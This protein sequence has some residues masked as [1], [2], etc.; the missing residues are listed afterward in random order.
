MED[1][2]YIVVGAGFAGLTA[3]LRLT[4]AG[5]SVLVIEARD[6][7]GGRTFTETRADGSYI[8]HG[9]TW[10]GPGQDRIHA[11][12]AELG[13][14]SYKQYVDG[15]AMMLVD[16]KAHRYGGTIPWSMRPW[17]SGNLATAFLELRR[18]CASIPV[19]APWDAARAVRWDATTLAQWL[20]WHVP[21]RQ[22]RR[23]LEMALAG[24]YTSAASEL[25]LLFVVFQLASAGGPDFVLGVEGAAED[26]RPVGGMGAIYR[27]MADRLADVLSLGAPARS[28]SQDSAGVTVRCDSREVR[29]SRVIVAVPVAIAGQ[30]VYEPALPVDRSLLHQRM[31]SGAVLKCHALYDEPF[32]RADGLTG[33]SAAPGTAAAVTIDAGMHE[34]GPGVLAI[35]TEGPTARTLSRMA[36]ADR[37]AAIIDALAHRFGPKASVPIEFTQQDWTAEQYSGG[38]MISH[39]PPGVLTE[40]G[41]ALRPACGRIHWAG[42]ETSAVMYGFVDGAVRSGER[43]AREVLAADAAA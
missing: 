3:A 37:R 26:A 28:I 30:I 9:G 42:T 7:P 32:W 40:F 35:V 18:M 11:L 31:P 6:R 20:E 23:L 41:H 5:H 27:P 29:G 19:E 4:Q 43:A 25:S 34:E 22:A 15:Q 8:D 39:A 33:Q 1:A 12:M 10:V 13:V 24:S 16:G 36:P 17:V 14:R 2:D 21:V 38:G